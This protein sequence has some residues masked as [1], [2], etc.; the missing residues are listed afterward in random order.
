MKLF[1]LAA[2][3]GA[4][5]FAQDIS[6]TIAGNVIDPFELVTTYGLDAVRYFLLREV[7]FGADGDFSRKAMIGRMNSD[8]AN[9]FGN[10]A[11]RTLSIIQKNCEGKVPKPGA[12]AWLSSP[13]AGALGAGET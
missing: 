2:L 8:L 9:A 6:G 3:A 11:Q 10:L 4:L 13:W 1:L 12:F 7:P 5:S